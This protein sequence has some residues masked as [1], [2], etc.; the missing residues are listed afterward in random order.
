MTSSFYAS[1]SG[2]GWNSL[3]NTG[4]LGH[5]AAPGAGSNRRVQRGQ[6]HLRCLG[7]PGRPRFS[8]CWP[9]WP[10]LCRGGSP[11]RIHQEDPP[12][13]FPSAAQLRKRR[14]GP[15]SPC[16]VWDGLFA[17]LGLDCGSLWIVWKQMALLW[18]FLLGILGNMRTG[19]LHS[20]NSGQ[21][22]AHDH[23]PGH[24]GHMTTMT[25]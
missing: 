25:L 11:R 10:S 24:I 22:P 12:G 2:N 18:R 20:L 23:Q 14:S 21:L 9:L 13:G 3:E 4:P 16:F 19:L 6:R 17:H 8:T 15:L 7:M 5:W 1:P